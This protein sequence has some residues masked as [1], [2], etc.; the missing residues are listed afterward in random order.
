M[1]MLFNLAMF[2]VIAGHFGFAHLQWFRWDRVCAKLTDLTPEEAVRTAFLGRSFASYNASIGLG[3]GL[4]FLLA[5]GAR[6]WVQAVTLALIVFTAAIG[7]AGT[8]GN[9]ILL[10]RL[11]PA[12]VALAMTLFAET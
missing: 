9:L 4:S 3:L 8:R 2:A 1:T 11:A 6:E 12:A 10:A 7:A 5:E